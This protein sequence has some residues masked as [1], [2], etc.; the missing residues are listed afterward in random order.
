MKSIFNSFSIFKDRN[1]RFFWMSRTFISV[2]MFIQGVALGWQ[3]YN[4]AR[5]DHDIPQSAFFVGMVGLAQFLPQ[6]AL[7]LVAGAAAD[8]HDRLLLLRFANVMQAAAALMLA[9][10]SLAEKPPMAMLF[11]AAFVFGVGR[12]FAMPAASSLGPMIVPSHLMPRAIAWNT[13]SMQMG[14]IIGPWIGGV[15]CAISMPLTYSVSV[16]LFVLGLMTT[17]GIQGKTKPDFSGGSRIQLIKE[18][19]AYLWSNKIVLGAISL[20]LFAVML[21]GVTAL[22]PVYAR[23]IL[24]IGADGFGMLRAGAA[25]GGASMAVIL[26]IRPIERHAGR[27]MLGAVALFG[28]STIVFAL[29][30]DVVLSMVALITLG[31]ADVVSVFVRQTLIQIV[32]PDAMRGRVSAVSAL[33]ISASNELGEFESGVLARFLGPV[34]SAIAGGIGAIGVTLLWAKLFPALRQADRLA[35]DEAKG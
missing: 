17:F 33:F 4:L 13:L 20:D 16:G 34:G 15:L 32:T 7:S 23:D 3:V 18:G 25:I 12:A 8:K 19:F 10:L 2:A 27:M 9:M 35:V 21:G 31:G 28:V 26:S 24:N 14:M 1:F 29:S 6:F 30:R 22:L 11:V 5:L